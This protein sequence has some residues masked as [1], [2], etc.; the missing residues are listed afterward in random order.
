MNIYELIESLIEYAFETG[1]LKDEDRVY[2]RNRIMDILD[3]SEYPDGVKI[4]RKMSHVEILEAIIKWAH[5]NNLIE[6]TSS[7]YADVLDSRIMDSLMPRP[8]EVNREFWLK[9]ESSVKEATGYY[10]ALA[11]NSHYIRT[12]R[13]AKN[14]SWSIDSEYGRV[15]IS[16]NLSKPEKDPKAIALASKKKSSKYPKCLLCR[17]NEGYKG[18]VDHPGRAN[19]RLVKM[20]INDEI[21][22]LQY[23]PYVY[24]NEHSIL[25]KE[26]H[27]P[28]KID[29]ETFKRLIGFL[30]ILPHY[31]IG[32]NADLPIVG[33]SMLSHDHYQC[34]NYV[35][36]MERARVISSLMAD[37]IK[38]SVLKWPLSVI[39]ISGKEKDKVVEWCEKLR[40]YWKNYSDEEKNIRAYTGQ[41]EHNTI[42]PIARK[43]DGDYQMDMVLRNNRTSEDHS[44]GIFHPHKDVH[45]V[46]KENI[47]L[48]EVMGLAIL[49]SRLDSV[50]KKLESCLENGEFDHDDQALDGFERI[51]EN[52]RA[53]YEKGIGVSTI[54]LIKL[55]IGNVFLKG[56]EDC[57]VY[58]DFSDMEKFL[59]DFLNGADGI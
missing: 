29:M 59:K 7:E 37:G 36:P 55:E 20:G 31:F 41:V 47:G 48:I 2:S 1:L 4:D 30:D 57:G 50:M 32:S 13:I 52:I 8:S 44:Y 54:E 58:K 27:V 38:L 53:N 28:M 56:L 49:P 45:P 23:S 17:E 25:L 46:K 3:I 43:K 34:G 51:Y 35:F 39:R 18:R 14:K 42:T 40:S 11:E 10:Y 9:Y 12:D 21:W 24:F 26:E 5:E 19:H 6:S 15:E 16:I 22:Y 33:G